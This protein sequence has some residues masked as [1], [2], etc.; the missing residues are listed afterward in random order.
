MREPAEPQGCGLV[1]GF[2]HAGDCS[3]YE[4]ARN[5]SASVSDPTE[6]VGTVDEITRVWSAR[7]RFGDS[8]KVE[9]N[10]NSFFDDAASVKLGPAITAKYPNRRNRTKTP[11]SYQYRAG[12]CPH[13][14]ALPIVLTDG[15]TLIL[16][17]RWP[18]AVERWACR[19]W[20]RQRPY[21]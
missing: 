20:P 9:I 17:H 1:T 7:R 3:S 11:M 18:Q 10:Q 8:Q 14:R 12:L 21:Y 15:L 2:A 6:E 16:Q 4:I 5:A 13:Y 19:K